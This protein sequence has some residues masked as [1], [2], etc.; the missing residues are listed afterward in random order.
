MSDGLSWNTDRGGGDIKRTK[1]CKTTR[2]TVQIGRSA[3]GPNFAV[4]EKAADGDG[5]EFLLK[6]ARVMAGMPVE[7][8]PAAEAR[9]KERSGEL[10][11]AGPRSIHP[12]CLL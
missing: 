2:I 6:K 11:S 9:K 1:E 5:S 12:Q 10:F 4:A 8:F 3:Y 7:V